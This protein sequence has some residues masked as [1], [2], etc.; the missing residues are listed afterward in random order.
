MPVYVNAE[1][2]SY[3]D[4][5]GSAWTRRKSPAQL[6]EQAN[7]RITIGLINN[8]PQAAFAATERQFISV[9]DAASEDLDVCLSLY[10]LPGIQVRALSGNDFRNNYLSIDNL[11][12]TAVDALIVTGKEPVTEHLKDEPCWK[13]FT[14]VIDWAQENTYSTVWSCLAAHAAVQHL[15]GIERRK[16]EQ[17]HFGVFE[18]SSVS[19]HPLMAEAPPFFH[20][21]HSRW[22]SV[23]EE[24][25]VACGYSI[26]TRMAGAGA[27]SFVKEDKSLFV[28]FQ[29]HP[30]YESDT[31]LREYRRD[32]GRYLN[33]EAATYPEAP[34]GYFDRGTEDVLA[35]L[36]EEACQG[37]E[38]FAKVSRV[39]E[40]AKVN[41]TWRSTTTVIYRN[42]LEQ[43]CA[44]KSGNK[45]AEVNVA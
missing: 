1:R 18:C 16:N 14:Q 12:D 43:L 7:P 8:M 29:G 41:D 17:K 27:D 28:F 42:W 44:R 25:L 23:A 45:L 32:V 19:G 6:R 2:T 33:H 40:A 11:W 34:A 37:G 38:V 22:N 10:S 26:L 9:L 24:E 15:D 4:S 13:S 30:E 39:L 3:G 20:A 21:P 5:D 36:R 31:L 35:A